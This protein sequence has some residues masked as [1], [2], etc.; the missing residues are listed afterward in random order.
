[1]R[2]SRPSSPPSSGSRG[3]G[4]RGAGA[5]AGSSFVHLA[6]P[7][8]RVVGELHEPVHVAR[9]V[10]RRAALEGAD[11]REAAAHVVSEGGRADHRGRDGVH[12]LVEPVAL[13]VEG[14]GEAVGLERPEGPRLPVA[15]R[16]HVEAGALQAD[17]GVP[18]GA[19]GCARK[20]R[21]PEVSALPTSSRSRRCAGSRSRSRSGRRP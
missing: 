5:G 10:G 13:E 19:P 8:R 14:P 7:V 20:S 15:L 16:G 1:M 11:H 9:V 6:G 17:R 3:R 4:A 21:F 18:G 2:R 12:G